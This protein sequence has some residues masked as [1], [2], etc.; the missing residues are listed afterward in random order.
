MVLLLVWSRGLG[1]PA[2]G[3]QAA[4]CCDIGPRGRM[5]QKENNAQGLPIRSSSRGFQAPPAL[6]FCLFLFG[7]RQGYVLPPKKAS[8]SLDKSIRVSYNW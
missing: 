3:V 6:H 8:P 2:I 1:E 7:N 4:T 5:D